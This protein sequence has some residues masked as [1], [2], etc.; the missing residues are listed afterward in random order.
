MGDHCSRDGK[1]RR[2]AVE[3]ASA[4]GHL[5]FRFGIGWK[6]ELCSRTQSFEVPVF[7]STVEIGERNR[8]ADQG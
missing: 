4:T 2:R 6:D 7:G 8:E 1:H 5:L 3:T